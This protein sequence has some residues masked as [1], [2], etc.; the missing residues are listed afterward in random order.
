MYQL[1]PASA[2][3]IIVIVSEKVEVLNNEMICY[4]QC[5][6]ATFL[7][8]TI[9]KIRWFELISFIFSIGILYRAY[10]FRTKKVD[11]W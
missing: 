9:K 6:S 5:Y 7:E 11:A 3:V 1:T 8:F 10:L 2:N 4:S